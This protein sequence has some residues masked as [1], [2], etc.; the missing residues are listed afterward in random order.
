M[1]ECEHGAPAMTSLID[2]PPFNSE[3]F[4]GAPFPGD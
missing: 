1:K 2:S 4:R 3:K